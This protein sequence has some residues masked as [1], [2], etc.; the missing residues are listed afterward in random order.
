MRCKIL[1]FNYASSTTRIRRRKDMTGDK[2][3]ERDEDEGEAG[4]S[5]SREKETE[6]QTRN[7]SSR[8]E[9]NSMK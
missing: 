9:G 8:N 3:E 6:H 5:S 2:K 4:D 1:S 7:M